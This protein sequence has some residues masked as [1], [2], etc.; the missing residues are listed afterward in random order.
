M[1]TLSNSVPSPRYE[2]ETT[3][4]STEEERNDILVV[5]DNA[6]MR[7]YIS[8]ILKKKYNVQEAIDGIDALEKIEEKQPDL[9]LTDIMMPRMDGLELLKSLRKNVNTN[10]IP[11][12]FLSARAGEESQVEGIHYLADDY[13]VKPFTS[14]VLPYIFFSEER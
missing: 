1:G 8:K 14:N 6:D 2:K 3:I 5:D 13:V 12:V 10:M 7:S 11:V 9:I 4:S